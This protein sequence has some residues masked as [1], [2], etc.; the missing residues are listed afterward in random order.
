ML[1]GFPDACL[2]LLFSSS[3]GRTLDGL[4]YLLKARF[5]LLVRLSILL[6]EFV[7]LRRQ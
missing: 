6:G 4:G 3:D 5:A 1:L 7:G 2:L